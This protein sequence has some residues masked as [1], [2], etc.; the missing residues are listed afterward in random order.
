MYAVFVSLRFRARLIA[1]L[2]GIGVRSTFIDV[3]RT[4]RAMVLGV[5]SFLCG[6]T[7]AL[8]DISGSLA[9]QSAVALSAGESLEAETAET[10]PADQLPRVLSMNLCADQ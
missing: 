5:A 3:E 4:R 10:L 8:A 1:Q 6:G 2:T 9:S 7:I